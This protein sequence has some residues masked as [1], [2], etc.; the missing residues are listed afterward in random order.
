M[1]QDRRG[2]QFNTSVISYISKNELHVIFS[3]KKKRTVVPERVPRIPRLLIEDRDCRRTENVARKMFDGLLTM[4]VR[5]LF[6]VHRGG[7]R[8]AGAYAKNRS[9]IIPVAASLGLIKVK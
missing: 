6:I 3:K 5:L 2:S 4:N 7:R 9:S 1:R 8:D